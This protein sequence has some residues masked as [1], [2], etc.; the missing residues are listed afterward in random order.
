MPCRLD[1]RV[2]AADQRCLLHP[3]SADETASDTR[4][5]TA[6]EC[7][8]RRRHEDDGCRNREPNNRRAET[9][10]SIR[11]R[12]TA[13]WASEVRSRLVYEPIAEEVRGAQPMIPVVA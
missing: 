10:G 6:T 8:I 1:A 11:A 9:S 7:Q 13:A 5:S 12:G 2:A 4:P 3:V